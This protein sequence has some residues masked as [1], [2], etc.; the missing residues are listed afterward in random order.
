MKKRNYSSGYHAF[1]SYQRYLRKKARL[2]SA[3]FSSGDKLNFLNKRIEKLKL[4]LSTILK[5]SKVAT[6]A[7]SVILTLNSG[8][9]NGQT[10]ISPVT[11]PYGL[12]STSSYRS[13]PAFAV[14]GFRLKVIATSSNDAVQGALEMVQRRVYAFPATPEKVDVGELALLKEP[15][16]P[17]TTLQLPEPIAGL[18]PA[19]VTADKPQ[20]EAPV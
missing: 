18:L 3:G 16:V 15:P 9:A 17:L 14:V 20:V 2:T 7:A 8:S 11:N 1:K 13:A 5:K 6:A 10:F 4:F 12:N 19:S